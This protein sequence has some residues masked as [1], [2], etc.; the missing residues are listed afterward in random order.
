MLATGT[1]R[2]NPA[3]WWNGLG[4]ASTLITG[5]TAP[6]PAPVS[7][8]IEQQTAPLAVPTSTQPTPQTAPVVTSELYK[9]LNPTTP[10][11]PGV[12]APTD[13]DTAYLYTLLNITEGGV[14]LFPFTDVAA[15]WNDLWRPPLSPQDAR[16]VAAMGGVLQPGQPR[17]IQGVESLAR[18]WAF[19]QDANVASIVDWV[20]GHK[21]PWLTTNPYTQQPWQPSDKTADWDPFNWQFGANRYMQ[22][23]TDKNPG[24]LT[25]YL[26]TY[27]FPALTVI[28][29]TVIGA[30][31]IGPIFGAGAFATA[32]GGAVGAVIGSAATTLATPTAPAALVTPG[33]APTFNENLLQ[34]EV[35]LLPTSGSP[36]PLS[37][38]YEFGMQSSSPIPRTPEQE[39]EI[40]ANEDFVKGA[41]VVSVLG[42]ILLFGGK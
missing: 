40:A 29:A 33:L 25:H 39:A 26:Q 37:T 41:L 8:L 19:T 36:V 31:G 11:K 42:A 6:A 15:L 21:L 17:S 18:S 2:A 14:P 35:P 3:M 38:G 24:G 7:P 5:P 4:D 30:Y 10:L 34:Q 23:V 12:P 27:V 13:Q 28:A 22:T 16:A 9:K 1:L 20:H 32:G